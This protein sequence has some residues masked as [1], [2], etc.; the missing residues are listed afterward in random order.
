MALNEFKACLL[1]GG[2]YQ[3]GTGRKIHARPAKAGRA[4]VS[5]AAELGWPAV[6]K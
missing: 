6:I 1:N 2:I 5:R 3:T 4:L